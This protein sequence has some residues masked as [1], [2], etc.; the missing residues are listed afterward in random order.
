MFPTTDETEYGEE[1]TMTEEPFISAEERPD[2]TIDLDS[3]VGDMTVRQLSQLL[4]TTPQV[5]K[6]IKELTK[7]EGK[8]SKE[9]KDNKD[10]KD[11]KDQKDQKDTKDVKDPKDQK[12]TKD[13]KDPKDQKD[14]KDGKDT[15]DHKDPKE[16]RDE[17]IGKDISDRKAALFEKVRPETPEVAPTAGQPGQQGGL[18][19]LIQRT[20]GL[21][22]EAPGGA[23]ATQE[24]TAQGG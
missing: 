7:L 23:S 21:E 1:A 13:Q 9:D 14:Q 24:G 4:G 11:P 5:V 22:P 15:K 12:D 10:H 2:L 18:D 16:A 3:R 19:P 17:K 20:S 8:E 6:Q